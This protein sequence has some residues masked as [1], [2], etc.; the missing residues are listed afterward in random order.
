MNGLDLQAVFDKLA[1]R[2]QDIDV[3][4]HQSKDD[5]GDASAKYDQTCEYQY[6]IPASVTVQLQTI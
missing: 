1:D 5:G 3:C 6:H 2:F 4:A